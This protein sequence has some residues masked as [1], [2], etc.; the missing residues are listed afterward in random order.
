MVILFENS[1]QYFMED[2]LKSAREMEARLGLDNAD[3]YVPLSTIENTLKV[4]EQ[5]VKDLDSKDFQQLPYES[6][7]MTK[8]H[9]TIVINTLKSLIGEF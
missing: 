5:K 7:V 1:K 3:V 2:S 9:L 4:Y 6:I 8:N